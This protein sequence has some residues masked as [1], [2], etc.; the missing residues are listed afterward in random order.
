MHDGCCEILL[1]RAIIE[2]N[3]IKMRCVFWDHRA[4]NKQFTYLKDQ[5]CFEMIRIGPRRDRPTDQ[6]ELVQFPRLVIGRCCYPP[7][8]QHCSGCRIEVTNLCEICDRAFKRGVTFVKL[9]VLIWELLV[10]IT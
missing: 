5:S 6:I 7:V 4:W 9:L 1:C 2:H 8:V 3:L 10:V